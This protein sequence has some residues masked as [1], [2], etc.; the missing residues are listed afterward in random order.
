[1][2]NEKLTPMTYISLVVIVIGITVACTT[3]LQFDFNGFLSAFL[4]NVAFV[5]RG[6][7]VKKALDTNLDHHELFFITSLYSVILCFIPSFIEIYYG[8]GFVLFFSGL[9]DEFIVMSKATISHYLYNVFS[10]VLLGM[11]SPLSHSVSGSVKRLFIIYTSIIYFKNPVTFLN[12]MASAVAI[13]GV[14]L[15]SWDRSTYKTKLI[16]ESKVTETI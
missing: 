13:G 4:S 5:L 11:M 10:Y 14:L 8:T 7:Y 16:V 9:R 1:M 15:Y 6:V 2:L 12:T 3:E